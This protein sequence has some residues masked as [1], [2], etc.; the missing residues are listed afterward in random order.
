M[1][2]IAWVPP[3]PPRP[4]WIPVFLEHFRKNG[5]V[6]WAAAEAGVSRMTVYNY[7][8]N[9]P[10][11]AAAFREADEESL[12]WVEAAARKSAVI[13][14]NTTMQQFILRCRKREVYGDHKTIAGDPQKPLVVQNLGNLSDAELRRQIAELEGRT[15]EAGAGEASED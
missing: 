11:F 4:E 2:A 9:D 6:A 10:E 1:N 15:G 3:K 13:D 12:E 8:K 5:V 7:K 14:G